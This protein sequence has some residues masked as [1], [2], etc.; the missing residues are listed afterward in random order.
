MEQASQRLLDQGTCWLTINRS[1][2][3]VVDAPAPSWIN[4]YDRHIGR[5]YLFLEE[6]YKNNRARNLL[7]INELTVILEAANRAGIEV[8][9]LTG[10][11]LALAVYPDPALRPM[12]DIDFLVHPEDQTRIGNIMANLGYQIDT[13]L[14][15]GG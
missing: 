3:K 14:P 11:L 5:V 13:S 2:D 8:I 9:P 15:P 4:S 1:L 6:E 12:A 7:I 10:V